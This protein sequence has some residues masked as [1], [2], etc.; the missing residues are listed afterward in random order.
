MRLVNETPMKTLP[1]ALSIPHGGTDVPP[2]FEPL[3]V[4][5]EEDTREDV[6]HLTREIFGVEPGRI[7]HSLSFSTSRTFVDLNR[8]PESVGEDFP[9]G[10]VKRQTHLHRPVFSRFPDKT[11]VDKVLER[12]YHPYHQELSRIVS[13]PNVRL[14]LDCHSMAPKGLPVSPDAAATERP[15][16]C[17]GHKGGQ[18]APSEMIQALK[19]IMVEVYEVPAEQIW[20]DI[21][22]NGGY[23]TRTHGCLETPMIQIEF[24]RGYYLGDQEGKPNPQLSPERIEF[25]QAR[26][27]TTLERLAKSEI[28]R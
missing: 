27:L 21:P 3:V 14:T 17:L 20:V 15:L 23:I 4:A 6:D 24:N 7:Q 5:T 10:V 9:D 25:W 12:L 2:E 8:P 16:I 13:D 11:D 1:F 19:S 18:S 28:F 26:F 22:F